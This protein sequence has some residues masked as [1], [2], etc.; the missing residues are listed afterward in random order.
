MYLLIYYCGRIK[1]YLFKLFCFR[2]FC[3][4][5]LYGIPKI[6]SHRN[7]KIGR[8]TRI[9]GNVFIHGAGGVVIG[10]NVTLSYG[11]TILS[12]G[13]ALDS[14]TVNKTEKEHV[15]KEIVIADNVWLGANV[16]IV[17]GVTIAEGVVVGAG[18]VVSRSLDEANTLYAGIPAKKIKQL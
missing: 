10:K 2:F 13:Y 14:W 12:T 6:L 3:G 11:T 5:T 18:S 4:V 15:H 7:V 16:T 9:N 17:S 8:G 1:A